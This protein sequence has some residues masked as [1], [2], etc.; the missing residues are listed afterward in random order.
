MPNIWLCDECVRYMVDFYIPVVVVVGGFYLFVA[1]YAY[2]CEEVFF[3]CGC[4]V[5]GIFD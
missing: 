1:I 3:V 4:C 5:E 2:E